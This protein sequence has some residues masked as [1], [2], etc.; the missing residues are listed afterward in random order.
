MYS[1]PMGFDEQETRR[2]QALAGQAAVA[3]QNLHSIE[4]AE[5]QA[6]EAQ[7]RS[8]ELALLNSIVTSV[9]ASQDLQ[10]SLNIVTN[11]LGRALKARAEVAL[12][13][14]QRHAL[15][16]ETHYSPSRN[17]PPMLGV[18]IP[19]QDNPFAQQ[20]IKTRRS[21]VIDDAQHNRLTAPIHE[22]LR[23]LDTQALMVIPILIGK[24]IFGTVNLH[25]HEEGRTFTPEEIRLAEAVVLQTSTAIQNS[26]LLEETRQRANQLQTAAE[27]ARDTSSTLALD[28]LL[29]RLV[30]LLCDRFGYYHASIF[31]LD[32]TGKEAVVR[33]STGPAGDEM[34]RIGHK[35]PVGG[36]SLIGRVTQ[37][38]RPLVLN[39]LSAE[40]ALVIFQP[41]PLLPLTQAELGIPLKIGERVIGALD[42]QANRPNAFPDDDIAVLQIL[43]DQIAVAVDNARSYE[44][45]QTAVEEIREAD[46]LKSQFLANMSHELRTPLN[47]II[48]FSR[49]ILKGID[50]PVS[51]LQQQDLTAIYNSGQHLLGLI[52][53]VL[54]LS[55]IEAGKMELA[56]EDEVNLG[57]IIRSVMSTTIGLIKDK[58]IKL[59]QKIDPKLPLLRVDSMKIRQ[60]LLNLLSNAAKFT[61][62][63]T[64]TVEATTQMGPGENPEVIVRIIDT[65]YGIAP[66]DQAKLFQPFS[67]VDGSLTR[68][69]GGS[70]L[71]L[72]ICQHLVQ[73]HGGKIGVE[74]EIGQGSIFYFTIP[75][76]PSGDQGETE[77]GTEAESIEQTLNITRVDK[78][79]S[80]QA[81]LK[82]TPTKTK[83]VIEDTPSMGAVDEKASEIA[84]QILSI[85]KDPQV[86]D[87]YKRYLE[88]L[89]YSV[90][91]VTEL[92]QAIA[93]A[94]GIQPLV[95]TLDVSMQSDE[96]SQGEGRSFDGWQVLETLKS[97][98]LTANIPV[99]VCTLVSEQERAFKLGADDYLL[100][101]IL[102]EDL[103]QVIQEIMQFR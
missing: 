77:E 42:V 49:V 40:E 96:G 36:R 13:N 28:T 2:V 63:G 87:L 98:P 81:L 3:I 102:E 8:E 19:V 83:E 10:A 73:L 66:K 61:D 52:N 44:L 26:R 15:T 39:D 67:Q 54:D 89:H 71:G 103:V 11:Q 95:I 7:S 6:R 37:T 55:R 5:Q 41:N 29:Q 79:P 9:T 69:T 51:D 62:E 31:L 86:I 16:V 60:V 56:F 47:S 21:L 34:K 4:L 74:S 48:G 78:P 53:D 18:V 58:Q 75:I 33:E 38:G 84:G 59:N 14:P 22:L 1:N 97:D 30:N 82:I 45:A 99:I 32:E 20:V 43:A 25:I 88:N 50:G 27:I 12:Y 46:R 68:K 85:D 24:Q 64:I 92:D 35:L 100:K 70:G 76:I 94:R 80:G 91:S 93:A 23:Q 65:G 72:S 17:S 57:D 90:V 101:P